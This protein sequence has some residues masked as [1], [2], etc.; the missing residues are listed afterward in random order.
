MTWDAQAPI[1]TQHGFED[2]QAACAQLL[3]ADKE[4]TRV[5]PVAVSGPRNVPV[6]PIRLDIAGTAL[7]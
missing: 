1:T 5:R 2:G 7:G 4:H 6:S 3:E